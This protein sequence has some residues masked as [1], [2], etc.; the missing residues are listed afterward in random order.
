MSRKST[1]GQWGFRRIGKR[2]GT[3]GNLNKYESEAE[4]FHFGGGSVWARTLLGAKRKI[5]K[6]L[7]KEF[8]KRARL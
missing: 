6:E 4:L 7:K 5:R 1:T 3:T 8:Q 2:A